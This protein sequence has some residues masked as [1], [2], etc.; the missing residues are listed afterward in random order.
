MIK[1]NNLCYTNILNVFVYAYISL[2]YTYKQYLNVATI[3][4]SLELIRLIVLKLCS[5]VH[6]NVKNM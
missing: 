6:A 4:N 3:N 5:T 1:H 2:N